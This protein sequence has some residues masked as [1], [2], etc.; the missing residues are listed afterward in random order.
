MKTKL[1][2]QWARILAG[3]AVGLGLMVCTVGAQGTPSAAPEAVQFGTKSPQFTLDIAEG[4][5]VRKGAQTEAT[6]GSVL[7]SISEQHPE[8][9]LTMAPE[10]TRIPIMNLKLRAGHF[11]DVLEGLRVA[12]GY[13]FA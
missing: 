11:E 12:S 1:W 2:V 3:S 4:K 13:R 9:S 7:E 6:L 8:I 10:V 5:F